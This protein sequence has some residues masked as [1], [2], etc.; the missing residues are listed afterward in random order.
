MMCN[1]TGVQAIKVPT[2]NQFCSRVPDSN[3][4]GSVDNVVGKEVGGGGTW[5]VVDQ[6]G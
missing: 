5:G 4:I 6:T 1:L 3:G 2:N